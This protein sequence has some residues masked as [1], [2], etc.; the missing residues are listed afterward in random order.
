MA[1]Q[2]DLQ[3]EI[4]KFRHELAQFCHEHGYFLEQKDA[5]IKIENGI[6][7]FNETI[8]TTGTLLAGKVKEI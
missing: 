2:I 5:T 8:M 7:S 4:K 1:K 3:S 6:L